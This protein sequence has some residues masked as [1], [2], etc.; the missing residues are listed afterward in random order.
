MKKHH[1][2]LLSAKD[3]NILKHRSYQIMLYLFYVEDLK[4]FIL[5]SLKVT[6]DIHRISNKGMKLDDYLNQIVIDKIITKDEKDELVSLVDFR[7]DI[8][9]EIHKMVS[10]F[11]DS[12][13]FQM[14]NLD[15]SIKEN[16]QY[17]ALFRIKYLTEKIHK[18]FQ[19]RYAM[20]VS[21]DKFVFEPAEKALEYESKILFKK[22][23]K[24]ELQE[25]FKNKA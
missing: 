8:S 16:Y 12:R 5:G 4:R 13:I 21:F 22:I 1:V 23:L 2:K 25:Q 10:D 6:N 18:G 7:N 20:M 9:H 19:S 11:G 15:G 24:D 14:S 3:R 17:G